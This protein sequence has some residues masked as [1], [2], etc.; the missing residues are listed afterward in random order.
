L[1]SEQLSGLCMSPPP[2]RRWKMSWIDVLMDTIM[3]NE[4]LY[5]LVLIE[6]PVLLMWE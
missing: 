3:Y 2:N 1:N 6:C 4:H 5:T